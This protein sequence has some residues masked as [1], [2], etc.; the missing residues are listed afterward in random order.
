[1]TGFASLLQQGAGQA[2]L[3]LP[4]AV[5]LGALHALEPGHSKTMMASFIVATR[6]GRREAAL[7]GL[8]AALSHSLAVWVLA[9]VA[10]AYGDALIADNAEPYI[11]LV[12]GI[13]VMSMAAWMLRRIGRVGR[14]RRPRAH[15][16]PHPRE[17]AHYHGDE[18]AHVHA[19]AREIERRFA[20][21]A[22]GP[23]QIVL[24]GLTGGLLPC[25]A[26]VTV[27]L[28]CLNVKQITL[29]AGMVAAFS[30]GLALTL[31]GVGL[32]ASWGARQAERRL[33]GFGGAWLGR[34]P[35]LSTLLMAA[36]G[37]IMASMG[38]ARI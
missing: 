8:S 3:F 25:P 7:L 10:L 16:H 18:D 27:L 6:G 29:G 14:A 32:A 15:G 17:Q 37:A 4:T 12:S 22:V 30:A 38:A 35:Y 11:L 2:W 9:A 33:S 1:M 36:L 20:G 28:V 13:A 23:G 19:H 26:A 31:V 34:L 5:M 21:H 24:F